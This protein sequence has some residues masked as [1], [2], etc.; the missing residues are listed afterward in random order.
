M[1]L[2]VLATAVVTLVARSAG[3]QPNPLD[4]RGVAPSFLMTA[5]MRLTLQNDIIPMAGGYAN[6]ATREEAAGNSV[7]GIPVSFHQALALTPRLTL[8]AFSQLGCPIDGSIGGAFAY[9]VPLRASIALVLSGGIIIAPG[10]LQP[11]GG[12][13]N[14]IVQQAQGRRSAT[15]AALRADLVWKTT[16]GR[17]FTVGVGS[18][19]TRHTLTFGGG[20]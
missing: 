4:T 17:T 16:S 19:G 14:A 20:F 9:S 12:L 1:R 11:Y 13:Q 3:A 10:Q 5:P 2:A 15:A 8:S 18:T 7:G 6:C